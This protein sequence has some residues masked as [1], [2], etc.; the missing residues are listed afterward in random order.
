MVLGQSHGG[1][2]VRD[3]HRR[4][5]VNRRDDQRW[6]RHGDSAVLCGSG[7]QSLAGS[8]FLDPSEHDAP[9]PH[10]VFRVDRG[11]G[12]DLYRRAIFR[13]VEVD[14]RAKLED[15]GAPSIGG[16]RHPEQFIVLDLE[17]V[18]AGHPNLEASNSLR[19]GELQVK[20]VAGLLARISVPSAR[21]GGVV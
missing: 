7:V 20:Q 21:I 4:S 11:K 5:E 8:E 18:E 1:V 10:G 17:G 3:L 16:N 19:N 12:F 13:H 6:Q 14:D 15:L 2:E 9:R